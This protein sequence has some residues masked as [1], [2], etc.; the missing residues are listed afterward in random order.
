MTSIFAREFP[1]KQSKSVARRLQL[2]L[3]VLTLVPDEAPA[4]PLSPD[5]AS[6]TVNGSSERGGHRG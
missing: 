5:M 1:G 2:T 4:E 6:L 3:G